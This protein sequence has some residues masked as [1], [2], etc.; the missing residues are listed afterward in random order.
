MGLS[1]GWG[2]AV[3]QATAEGIGVSPPFATAFGHLGEQISNNVAEYLGLKVC[4]SRAVRLLDPHVVFQMDSLL[5]ARQMAR[6]NAWACRSP[7]LLPLRNECRVL[8]EIL[9]ESG[10]V[11]EVS[12]IFREYNQVA[13]ALAN[14]GVE[15]VSVMVQTA[16][17]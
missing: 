14:E 17:W 5:V 7:D 8:G 3:W 2:S 4:L 6:R 1:G 13:D 11:W 15:N 9:S 10:V 16:L 12:H